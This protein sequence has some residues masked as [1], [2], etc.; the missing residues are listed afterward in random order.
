MQEIKNTVTE[1]KISFNWFISELNM[2]KERISE[3]EDISIET[4]NI[5]KKRKTEKKKKNPNTQGLWYNYKKYNMYIMVI[6]EE[7]RKE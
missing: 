5:K 6:S 4:S 3:L 7:E 2:A 1:M